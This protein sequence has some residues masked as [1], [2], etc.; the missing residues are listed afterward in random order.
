M[1]AL[2]PLAQCLLCEQ[3]GLTGSADFHFYDAVL[4]F[5]LEVF[6]PMG[7]LLNCTVAGLKVSLPVWPPARANMG[8]NV[9]QETAH[10]GAN[11]VCREPLPTHI[12]S[13]PPCP[14]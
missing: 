12:E 3:A 6:T 8:S 14:Q 2:L 4:H 9:T 5:T 11:Y 10:Q 13:D 7:L 1:A